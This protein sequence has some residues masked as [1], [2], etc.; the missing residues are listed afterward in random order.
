MY[1]YAFFRTIDWAKLIARDIEVTRSI[2]RLPF[3]DNQ[4]L[5]SF[6][7]K[8]PYIPPVLD[9]GDVNQIDPSFVGEQPDLDLGDVCRFLFRLI[10]HVGAHWFY[11]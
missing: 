6:L 8:V 10:V 7:C 3:D 2:A 9:K 1:R 4:Q 5:F 11:L